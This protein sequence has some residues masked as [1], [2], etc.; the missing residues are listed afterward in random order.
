MSVNKF[1]IRVSGEDKQ[2][3]LPISTDFDESLGREQGIKMYERTEIQD[4][5]NPIQDFETTRYSPNT[6]NPNKRI[7]Y[8]MFFT[9]LTIPN[10]SENG[11]SNDYSVVGITYPDVK[12]R[13]QSFTKSFFKFDFY[14]QPSVSGQRLYFSII[15]PTN[16]G[17]K[18]DRVISN[19]ENDINYDPINY[20]ISFANS[21]PEPFTYQ[22]ESSSFEF[23]SVGNKKEN[24]Y[25]QWLK[26]DF[27]VPNTTFYMSCKFFNALNGEIIKMINKPQPEN[28]YKLKP[29]DFY[30]YRL[31]FNRNNYTYT[32]S[33]YNTINQNL[34]EVGES[35]NNSIKFYQYINP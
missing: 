3:V 18:V 13:K 16:N 29:E 35:Q 12:T 19:D 6:Q 22:I 20:L 31:I 28:S 25:I 26:D 2:I 21:E 33:E 1:R 32:V 30:Y 10:G 8:D 27:L 23:A 17:S 4:N 11:Y 5:I 9:N 24:Y 15:L 34:S 14:D 7:Y